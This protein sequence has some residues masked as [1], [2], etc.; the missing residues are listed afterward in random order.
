[1]QSVRTKTSLHRLR[2]S[3]YK[4][5]KASPALALVTKGDTLVAGT[6]GSFLILLAFL[7][8]VLYIS[9][10]VFCCCF[11]LI[12]SFPYLVKSGGRRC[13]FVIVFFCYFVIV[14]ES[15]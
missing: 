14:K 6:T 4:N 12:I 1:M 2:E 5:W 3:A 13:C 8:S 10:V 15:V 11:F 7:S 9:V